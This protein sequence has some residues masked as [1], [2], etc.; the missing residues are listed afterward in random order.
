MTEEKDHL[1]LLIVASVVI[2]AGCKWL[3]D[4]TA[5]ERH[6]GEFDVPLVNW[7][8]WFAFVVVAGVAAMLLVAGAARLLGR[9]R[10]RHG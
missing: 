2:A 5:G 3:S 4:L 7:V 8:A 6:G 10:S 9:M 1:G